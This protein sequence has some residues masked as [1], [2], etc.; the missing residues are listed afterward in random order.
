[1]CKH[2][3]IVG[4]NQVNPLK[5]N[6]FPTAH[7]LQPI[8]VAGAMVVEAAAVGEPWRSPPTMEVEIWSL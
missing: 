5:K 1:M 8:L 4:V 3:K 7:H 6:T 2:P